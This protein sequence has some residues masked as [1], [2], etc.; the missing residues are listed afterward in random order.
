M[1]KKILSVSGK[2]GLYK[3]ISQGKNLLIAESLTDGKRIPVYMHEK[4]VS[5]SDIAIYTT[6]NKDLPLKTVLK[7]I[8]EK[9]QGKVIDFDKSISPINLKKYFVTILPNF[10]QDRVYSSDIRK[11]MTWYNI[12][13]TVGQTDFLTETEEEAPKEDNDAAPENV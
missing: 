9:E 10:D 2:P 4:V 8:W 13:V 5:L 11:I 1:L 3:L 7:N 12:L 6:D